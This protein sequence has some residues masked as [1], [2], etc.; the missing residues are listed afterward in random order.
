MPLSQPARSLTAS[1][2]WQPDSRWSTRAIGQIQPFRA[3]APLGHA[4]IPRSH[5]VVAI[6]DPAPTHDRHVS[7]SGAPASGRAWAICRA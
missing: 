1:R 7:S 3:L 4:L 2:L 6:G 5:P